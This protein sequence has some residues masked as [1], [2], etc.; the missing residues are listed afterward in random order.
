MAGMNKIT[1]IGNLGRDP[2]MR[3][4]PSG[5]AV[6]DFSVAVTR[7]YRT[8]DGENKEET[9]WFRVRCWERLAEIANQYLPK[10]RQVY[11]EGR[12]KSRTY[13]DQSGETRVSLDVNATE[14]VL[15]GQRSDGPGAASAP[16]AGND[17]SADLDS[18]PF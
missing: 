4:T 1:I 17:T 6:T 2:E 7:S 8:R 11:V 14:L 16:G 3:Y 9:E 5:S 13:Q 18:M 15:L 12:L 10:G